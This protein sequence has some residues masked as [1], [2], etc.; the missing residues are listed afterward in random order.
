MKEKS[1]KIYFYKNKTFSIFVLIN[2][3]FPP[4]PI[5]L[6]ILLSSPKSTLNDIIMSSVI[7]TTDIMMSRVI[8]TTAGNNNGDSV[9]PLS[10]III[11][12]EHH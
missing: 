5:Y 3:I 12:S 4:N 7:M 10:R 1:I 9:T 11:L 2:S 8:M 6:M